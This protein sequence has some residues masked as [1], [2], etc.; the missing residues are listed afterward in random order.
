MLIIGCDYHPSF[1]QIA[2]CDATTGECANRRLEHGGEAESFY[3]SLQGQ[4]ARVG[5]EA[6]GG[7]RWFERLLAECGIELWVGHPG[8]IRAAAPRKPKTPIAAT[9]NC[10]S[11]CC[12]RSVFPRLVVP[13]PEQRNLRQLVGHRHR[14]V[15]MQTR[16][17]NQ[18]Q[19]LAINE[20][21][22]L[23][24]ALWSRKGQAQLQALALPCWAE[25]K[26]CDLLALLA[27]LQR[28]SALLDQAVEA[29]AEASPVVRCLRQQRGVGPVVGLAYELTLLD[30]ARF[31]TSRQV[32]SYLG[33]IPSEHSS[34]G[35]Q[36]LGHI[37]KQ[38]NASVA[39]PAGG[40]G[41]RGGA[42][43]AGVAAAVRPP[44]DEE[45]PLDCRRCDGAQAGG[46]LVVVV[47]VGT[48]QRADRRVRFARRAACLAQWGAVD[49]RRADVALIIGDSTESSSLGAVCAPRMVVA[50]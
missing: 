21:L 8:K 35:K 32:A 7:T 26:R 17:K 22:R 33:L 37:S 2:C 24:R 43:G 42:L 50:V 19:A 49:P 30:P 36:R 20:G 39:R 10:C 23:R 28:R 13:S 25:Q 47:E 29:A 40:G 14:L 6:T 41:A 5:M 3:R 31:P 12:C 16:V 27:D 9:P 1:Q 34:G 38:G 46:A 4:A 48:R 45:E 44:G 18:L 15:Q 11:T